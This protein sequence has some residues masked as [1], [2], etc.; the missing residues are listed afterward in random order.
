MQP[1]TH[2]LVLPVVWCAA[3]AGIQARKYLWRL[4]STDTAAHSA[5][6]AWRRTNTADG[7]RDNH[8]ALKAARAHA[9]V[10]R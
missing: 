3:A 7:S 10:G 4:H 8:N 2:P 5:D 9:L 6:T 1:S